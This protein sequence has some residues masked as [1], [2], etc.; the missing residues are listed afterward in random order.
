MTR[1]DVFS[2]PFT[3]TGTLTAAPTLTL[4]IRSKAQSTRWGNALHPNSS[5]RTSIKLSDGIWGAHLGAL[6]M[7]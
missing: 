4:P 6:K 3:L 1:H 7:C 2:A 5:P